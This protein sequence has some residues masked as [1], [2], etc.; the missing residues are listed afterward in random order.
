MLSPT[1]Y[2]IGEIMTGKEIIK[3]NATWAVVCLILMTIDLY[4]YFNTDVSY[5][6]FI[7]F[8]LGVTFYGIGMALVDL[9]KRKDVR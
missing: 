6:K 5:Q 7:L 8:I 1:A 4:F 3:D 2:L 9:E